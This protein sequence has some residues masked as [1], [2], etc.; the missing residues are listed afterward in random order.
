MTFAI[1]ATAA[2]LIMLTCLAAA[3]GPTSASPDVLLGIWGSEQTLGPAAHGEL[4]LE[5][6]GSEWRAAIGGI[7][8]LAQRHGNAIT[9]TL[10]D[11]KGE[12]RGHVNT[13]SRSIDG[14]WIQPPNLGNSTGYASPVHLLPEGKSRWRGEVTPLAERVSFYISVQQSADGSLTAFI[15]NP[16]SNL[17]RRRLY[18]V[19]LQ[20]QAVEFSSK[21]QMLAGKYDPKTDRLSLAVL[22]GLP[23]VEFT[24]RSRDNAVGLYPRRQ[25]K[26]FVYHPPAAGNDGWATASLAAAGL[27]E[28][29]LAELVQKILQADP[30]DNPINVQSLLIAR[31][32]KLVFEEYFYGFDKD[33]PHD[34][35]SAGKTLAPVLLGIARDH[36][37]SVG[38]ATPLASL[39]PEYKPFANWDNRKAKLTVRDIMTMTSGLACDDN[40]DNS[41]GNEDTMQNQ[42]QQPDW[43]KFTLDLPM[44]SDPGG[45]QAIYCSAG[46]NLIGGVVRHVTGKWL[47]EFFDENYARPLGIDRYYLNLTPTGDAYM[48]GGAYLLPRDQLKLGQLYLSGGVWN[49]KR[50]VSEP[51]VEESTAKHSTFKPNL[52]D[53]P[54]H[55]YGYSWHERQFIKVGDHIVRNYSAGGNGGQLVIVIPDLDM[56][57][58]I[59]GG[60]YGDF[61][62]YRWELDLLPQFIV[63]AALG[64]KTH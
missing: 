59:N 21:G 16:E 61:R 63:P 4:V 53:E 55:D 32:G 57:V 22:E 8:A 3:E 47:P 18:Q 20:N 37:A 25:A 2:V 49:G 29:P 26:G 6:H 42:S 30:A 35:R 41:P 7:A 38:P 46:L 34:T 10:P 15:R 45:N 23:P 9:F 27:D 60:S 44:A 12:F 19:K 54:E 52:K 43:Y 33:R 5:A 28:K 24:R 17:F 40:D 31:H 1:R 48:G 50:V 36:G 39:F 64:D 62:W 51:W 58:G 56:V 14:H 13:G 11:G